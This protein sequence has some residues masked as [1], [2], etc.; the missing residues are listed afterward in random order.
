MRVKLFILFWNVIITG[1]VLWLVWLNLTYSRAEDVLTRFQIYRILNSAYTYYCD[2]GHW[3]NEQAYISDLSFDSCT[4]T[5]TVNR[6]QLRDVVDGYICS[7]NYTIT[8]T[9][10]CVWSYGH[11]RKP[12]TADDLFGS[13][14]TDGATETRSFLNYDYW[15]RGATLIESE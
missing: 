8:K 15:R 5:N 13:C 12:N 1:L 7:F 11:D 2:T 14:D 9:N 6:L 4:S 10:F 3:P